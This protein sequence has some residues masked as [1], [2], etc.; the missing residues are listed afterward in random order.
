M[1]KISSIVNSESGASARS[2]INTALASANLSIG[3]K[4][5]TTVDINN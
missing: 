1:S 3:T 5:N 2:K 4:T